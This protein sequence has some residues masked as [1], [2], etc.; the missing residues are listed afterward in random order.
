LER[1][2]R[3]KEGEVAMNRIKAIDDRVI[4]IDLL[5]RKH[6]EALGTPSYSVSTR[7]VA[8]TAINEKRRMLRY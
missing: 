1:S 8:S 5:I 2:R 3:E 6:L 7:N 4:E